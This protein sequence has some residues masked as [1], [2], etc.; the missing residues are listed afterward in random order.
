MSKGEEILLKQKQV[1]YRVCEG[2]EAKE[3]ENS[4]TDEQSIVRVG[5]RI[6]RRG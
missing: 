4:G 5:L 3:E 6:S 2:L 1:E